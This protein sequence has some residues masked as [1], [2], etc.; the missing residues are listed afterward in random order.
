MNNVVEGEAE[1]AEAPTCAEDAIKIPFAFSM[2]K[3]VKAKG[4]SAYVAECT[5]C[6]IQVR[7]QW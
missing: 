1:E 2:C 6:G 5:I 7:Q 4:M 3:N